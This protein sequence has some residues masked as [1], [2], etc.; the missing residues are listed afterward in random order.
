MVSTSGGR[1]AQGEEGG[2][3]ARGRSLPALCPHHDSLAHLSRQLWSAPVTSSSA[4]SGRRQPRSAGCPRRPEWTA[5]KSPTSWQME[6]IPSCP[7]VTCPIPPAPCALPTLQ[8]LLASL[9]AS[10]AQCVFRGATECPGGWPSPDP[11]TR[12]ARPRRSLRRDRGLRPW[13]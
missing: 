12:G 2:W 11:E 1:G 8:L 4:R 3:E 9:A 13:L 6:V 10:P 5:S 7:C